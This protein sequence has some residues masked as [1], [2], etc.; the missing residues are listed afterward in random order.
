[1]GGLSAALRKEG[2]K[3]MLKEAHRGK[4]V[5]QIMRHPVV[6]APD[7]TQQEAFEVLLE[8][9]L[10]CV[11]VVDEEGFLV[12]SIGDRQLLE[13]VIPDYL[14]MLED[15]SFLSETEAE[16]IDHP[17]GTADKPISEGTI[18]EVPSV[19]VGTNAVV[20]AHRMAHDEGVSGVVV[21]DGGK[22]AGVLYRLD[23]YAAMIGATK[24]EEGR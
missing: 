17:E 5:E 15:V 2:E 13:S 12:G 22:V 20:A 1:M 6:V 24:E 10:P 21:T 8:H 11:P 4:K 14:K 9:R 23:L 16:W 18:G 7:A 19:E 3:K